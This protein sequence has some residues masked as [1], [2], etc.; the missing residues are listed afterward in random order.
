MEDYGS[1][2]HACAFADGMAGAAL[3]E[4]APATAGLPESRDKAF[5]RSL[6]LHLRDPAIR[7]R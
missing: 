5:L 2:D 3:A 1:I 4:F 7:G 6:V